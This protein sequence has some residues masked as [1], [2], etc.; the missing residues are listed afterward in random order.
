MK[1]FSSRQNVSTLSELNITPLLDLAFVLLIIFMLT[2]PLIEKSVDL[3]VPTSRGADN[4]V[5]PSDIQTIAVDRDG[6]LELNGAPTDR[7]RLPDELRRLKAERPDAAV[8][9]RAHREQSV[10]RLVEV[11]DAAKAAA[12]T[13]IG[14][15]TTEEP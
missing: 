2:T 8:V 1:R 7:E 5:N 9:I 3:V 15:V 11:L 14:V 13:R 4:A 10:Q 12:I 6:N